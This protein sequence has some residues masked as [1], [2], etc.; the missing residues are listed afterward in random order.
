MSRQETSDGKN[1]V[2]KS[3]QML[4]TVIITLNESRNI[5][6]AILSV[7]DLSDD[8]VI[9]DSGSTDGTAELSKGHGARVVVREWEG[10]SATKNYAN[11]LAKHP[12]ILSLDADEAL[13]PELQDSIRQQLML[14][15]PDHRV[16][17]FNRLTNYCGSWIRY[18]GWY[19]DRK[20]RIWHRDFGKWE[21]E[22]H[23]NLV[24]TGE[25]EIVHLKGDLLHYSF[26]TRAEHLRQID[27]FT[28]L[29]A[30]SMYRNGSSAGNLKIWFGAPV[31]FIRDYIFRGGILDGRAGFDVCR[32]SAYAVRL[33]YSKLRKLRATGHL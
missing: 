5:G 10:Y 22:I 21:G 28:T 12:W 4:S 19:P 30:E 11:T 23:E 16:F 24:F 25:P 29:A 2:Y 8:I 18:S 3:S 14:P 27:R 33:K 31:R 15:L 9:V 20:I 6:R 17:S 32:G 13:S 26:Y 7:K 1:Y